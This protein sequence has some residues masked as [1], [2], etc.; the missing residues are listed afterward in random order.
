MKFDTR[1]P[2]GRSAIP[3]IEA[4]AGTIRLKGRLDLLLSQVIVKFHKELH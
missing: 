3:G 4:F 1:V 2:F